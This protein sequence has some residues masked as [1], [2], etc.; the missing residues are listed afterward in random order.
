M[1]LVTPTDIDGNPNPYYDDLEGNGIPDGRLAI[2]EGYVRSA[3][4]RPT[5]LALTRLMGQTTVFAARSR[6]APQQGRE[7]GKVLST[8]RSTD[9]ASQAVAPRHRT[10]APQ[11]SC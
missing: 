4:T 5:P 11:T 1:G 7:P 8:H 9:I 10:A 2:R 3:T 6:L